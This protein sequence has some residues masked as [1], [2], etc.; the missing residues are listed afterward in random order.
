MKKAFIQLHLAVFLAGFTGILGKLIDLSGGLITWYRMLFTVI[1][2]YFLFRFQGALK[3]LA[4]KDIIPV[5]GTGLV[6]ALH[7][8]FF[9]ASIKY[10]NATIGVVCF[11]LTSFFT[12]FLE[13]V[14]TGRKFD[15]TELLLSLLTLGGIYLIFHFDTRYQTGIILGVISAMF[16]ALFTIFNKR[17]V[18][19]HDTKT[20]TFYE[21][22]IGF[23]GL[24][25][26]M[27]LYFMAFPSTGP[28]LPNLS[29]T[30]YL[31]ILAIFCTVLL[32]QFQMNSLHKISAFTVNLTFNLE[33]LYTIALAFILFHENEHLTSKFYI[34]LSLIL[35]S[36]IFQMIKVFYGNK[37]AKRTAIAA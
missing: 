1:A 24:T 11:S 20:L 32:Y 15:V 4:V 16:A 18:V 6:I 31:L 12:A 3:K 13:P 33:P 29:D 10:A 7:W 35:L 9:Y 22:G 37:R 28:L 34:G 21:L 36:V 19:K 23:L 25:V 26:L 30:I 27:P 8:V 17:L 2:L 14:I 5:G